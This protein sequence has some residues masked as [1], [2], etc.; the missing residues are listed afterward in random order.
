MGDICEV[1]TNSLIENLTAEVEM[2]EKNIRQRM[3]ELGEAR[4]K[5][6]K[7]SESFQLE[8][9]SELFA[10]STGESTS[11]R[12]AKCQQWQQDNAVCK[13]ELATILQLMGELN[14]KMKIIEDME[15]LL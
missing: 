5:S 15:T 11:R 6:K 4:L 1:A 2:A 13:K 12:K 8:V 14:E 9:A 3:A 7:S 10:P